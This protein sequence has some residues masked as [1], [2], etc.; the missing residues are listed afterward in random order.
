MQQL[1]RVMSCPTEEAWGAA[2]QCVAWAHQRRSRGIVFR[3]DGDTNLRTYAD[4]SDKPDPKDGRAAHFFCIM[5]ANGPWVWEG[6]KNT[7][8]GQHSSHNETMAA[9]RAAKATVHVQKLLQDMG[10]YDKFPG[11][12]TP[13]PLMIDNAQA[14]KWSREEYVSQGNRYYERDLRYI[15]RRV[16]DG[17]ICTRKIAGPLNISDVGTKPLKGPEMRTLGPLLCGTGGLL[18]PLPEPPAT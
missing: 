17:S 13:T 11:L 14:L 18:P 1:T 4:S 3:S 9:N 16:E 15:K 5:F 8:E 6:R 10:L 2:M 7:E 12:K